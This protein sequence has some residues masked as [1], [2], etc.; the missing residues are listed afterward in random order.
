M[1]GFFFLF[2]MQSMR[3]RLIQDHIETA[4]FGHS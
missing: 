4:S 3:A 2:S 1:R